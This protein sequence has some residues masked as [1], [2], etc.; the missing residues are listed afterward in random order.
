MRN[1]KYRTSRISKV[2]H[3]KDLRHHH[4]WRPSSGQLIVTWIYFGW[5][6][7]KEFL[8]N[9]KRFLPIFDDTQ[10]I[11][12]FPKINHTSFPWR[13]E[14]FILITVT[15][16]TSRTIFLYQ[17]CPSL[18]FRNFYKLPNKSNSQK[19]VK[20]KSQKVK[21]SNGQTLKSQ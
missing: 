16:S 20:S 6:I 3:S 21:Q 12:T 15:R 19:L 10:L 5:L 2:E 8:P 4:T 17:F 9:I 11:S 13:T 1:H 18:T 7:S 14:T